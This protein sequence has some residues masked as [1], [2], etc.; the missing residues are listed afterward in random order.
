M[1]LER[2]YVFVNDRRRFYLT[3]TGNIL[4]DLAS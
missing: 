1:L 4:S 2:K 3:D